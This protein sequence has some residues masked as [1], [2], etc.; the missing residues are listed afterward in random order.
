MAKWK[1]VPP[2]RNPNYERVPV[3]RCYSDDLTQLPAVSAFALKNGAT[4]VVG[5]RTGKAPVLYRRKTGSHPNPAETQAKP[6]QSG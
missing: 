5:P 1:K 2:H 3:V 4:L 6:L